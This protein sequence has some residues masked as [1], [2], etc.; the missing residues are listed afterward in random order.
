MR[1]KRLLVLA[2]YPPTAAC[3]R[4][5]ACAYFDALA[6]RGIDAEL[7]P[8][9]GDEF[10][11]QFYRPGALAEKS[12]GLL[13]SSVERARLLLDAGAFD[14][15]FVQ[16]EAA[17]WGPA[18]VEGV[19]A[20]VR[21]IPVIFDFDDAIWMENTGS[22]RHP[23]LSRLLKSP[24]KT[25]G[26]LRMA[27]E[28]IAGSHYLAAYARRFA[29]R[30]L[31]S[32]TVVS[33]RAWTPLPGRLEGGMATEGVPV[34][35]WVGSHSTAVYL[36]FALP[37]L[38]ALAAAGEVFRVRL[39]GASR[40]LQ[41]DGIAV[42]SVPWSAETEIADFQRLDIGIAPMGDDEWA[43]G[44]CGF[45]QVQYMTVGVPYV[46]SRVGGGAGEIVRDGENGLLAGSVDEWQASLRSLL[47][48]R[49]LRA[50]LARAG[51]AEV[52]A[53]LSAEAQA[54]GVVGVVERAMGT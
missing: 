29:D 27:S 17:L 15:V 43:R 33:C 32:P 49:P 18:I 42:E 5:R 54:D 23:W 47:H 39:V 45:K 34:I 9:F 1:R 52:E 41:I 46:S 6:N 2:T 53:N 11:R 48:D 3:T 21:K 10:F 30:V 38:R 20:R 37:A 7:H 4:F 31:V 51:R 12:L 26:L 40:T 16:R 35:G 13:R 14:A 44:K 28:V 22:S 24:S 8:F 50:R 25:R 19:L 36:D